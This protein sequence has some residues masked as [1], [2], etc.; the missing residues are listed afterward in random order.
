[1]LAAIASTSPPS[2][3]WPTPTTPPPTCGTMRHER[4]VER[5]GQ[6]GLV[7]MDEA[8]QPFSSRSYLDRMANPATTPM[9][10]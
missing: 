5:G 4:I 1:M 3:T 9:C 2:S 10:C 7:V 6:G 8:Y